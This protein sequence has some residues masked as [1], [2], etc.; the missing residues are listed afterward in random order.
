M[1]KIITLLFVSFLLLNLSSCQ[2]K[3]VPF[4][5]E[6]ATPGLN[7]WLGSM[8]G[9]GV[10][11]SS[12]SLVYN[13]ANQ[14]DD[15][16]ASIPFHVRVIGF[17]SDHPRVF[18][19]EAIEGDINK[20]TFEADNYVLEP[21]EY[22]ASFN[23]RFFKP[24][25]YTEF[26]TENT[27]GSLVFRLKEDQHFVEGTTAYNRLNFRIA[28]SLIMPEFWYFEPT[29]PGQAST[30]LV[31]LSTFFGTYSQVKH[32]FCMLVMERDFDFR[33][34]NTAGTTVNPFHDSGMPLISYVY[35]QSL[36]MLVKAALAAYEAEHGT[37][38]RDENGDVVT[39]P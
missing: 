2:V 11:T 16:W 33:V 12:Q 14:M 3:E 19:L 34:R 36:A 1:K 22:Q 13:F 30:N 37:P 9:S 28:N 32:T 10:L 29:P 4:F 27:Q 8:T 20:V 15:T 31:P 35:A 6:N 25:G 23:I 5:D 17:A 38:L 21:G 18:S 7:I 39:L 24:N 26:N